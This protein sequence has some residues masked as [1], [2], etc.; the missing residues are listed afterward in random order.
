MLGGITGSHIPSGGQASFLPVNWSIE[1][2]EPTAEESRIQAGEGTMCLT[3]KRN[4]VHQGRR[5]SS[6][7][8]R[9]A[10]TTLS[11]TNSGFRMGMILLWG[12][13][14]WRLS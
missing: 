5:T 12:C 7:L 6:L 13:L 10:S 9:V 1:Q 11:A 4:M 2:L 14:R 8:A 3:M